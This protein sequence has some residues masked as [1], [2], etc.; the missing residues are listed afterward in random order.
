MA[1]RT[2]SSLLD[3]LIEKSYYTHGEGVQIGIWNINPLFREC[4]AAVEAGSTVD[5]AVKAAIVKYR[6]N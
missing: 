1:K 2:K 6:E 5:D 3:K 4:R